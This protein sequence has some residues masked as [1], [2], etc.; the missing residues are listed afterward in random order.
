MDTVS[1]QTKLLFPQEI[2]T[3]FLLA[4]AFEREILKLESK[5]IDEQ[6]KIF[7]F[8]AT[9]FNGVLHKEHFNEL[10]T[11]CGIQENFLEN[12]KAHPLLRYDSQSQILTFRY[13]FF[14]DFFKNISI[15]NYLKQWCS[16][17]DNNSKISHLKQAKR[18]RGV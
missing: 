14:N 3:D 18:W 11:Q 12:L 8:I 9:H 1:F 4:K 6:V 16:F 7:M 15:A 2:S 5:D 17:Y 10:C 13:D